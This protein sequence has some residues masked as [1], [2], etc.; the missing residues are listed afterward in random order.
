M[1]LPV[2]NTTATTANLARMVLGTVDLTRETTTVQTATLLLLL[3]HLIDLAEP[4]REESAENRNRTVR[5]LVAQV[6]TAARDRDDDQRQA[7]G[8][9]PPPRRTWG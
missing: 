1:S 6:E 4:R 2:H 5:Q 3:E 7:S 8:A 9:E